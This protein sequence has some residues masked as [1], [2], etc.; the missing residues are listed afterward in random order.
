M[1]R[2]IIPNFDSHSMSI[3]AQKYSSLLSKYLPEDFVDYAVELLLKYPVRFKIVKPRKTK[4][5][6]FK[7]GIGM[8]KPQ[9]TV[10]GNLNPY[11]FLITTIH[12]FAH[13]VTFERY[14]R[15]VAPHGKEWKQ[16][17]QELLM[18]VIGSKKLPERLEIA[19]RTSLGNTKAWSCTDQQLYRVLLT[20]DSPKDNHITLER[21]EKNSTFILDGRVFKKGGLRRTRY[22]CK[23]LKTNKEYLV[24]ALALVEKITYEQ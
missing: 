1:P 14:G 15:R 3:N 20:F 11:A 2:E 24:N 22:L 17:Y 6:D 23:E 21:L 9:I 18:P 13:L 19:L 8:E 16:T 4:L 10:N 5:G 12:E 7:I